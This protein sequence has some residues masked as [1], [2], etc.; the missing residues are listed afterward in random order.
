MILSGFK[1]STT[2]IKL[3][4]KK[5]KKYSIKKEQ[6]VYTNIFRAIFLGLSSLLVVS[7]LGCSNGKTKT[8]GEWQ[9]IDRYQVKDVLVK[10]ITTGLMWMRCSL[11]QSWGGSTC[12]GTAALYTWEQAMK[13]PSDFSYANYSDWRVPTHE[14]L[15]TLVYCSSGKPQTWNNTGDSCDGDFAKPTIMSDAFPQTPLFRIWSSSPNAANSISAWI[16]GFKHGHDG[17]G[18]KDSN[19]TLRLVRGGK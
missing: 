19:V 5:V 1:P 17:Y 14:E 2:Q 13:V 15:K 10:D 6:V 7:V 18:N 9:T 3:K 11:G 4:S 12:Q 16:V 8:V